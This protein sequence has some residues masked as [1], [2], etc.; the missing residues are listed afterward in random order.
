MKT[1]QERQ[2]DRRRAKLDEV[3]RQVREGSLVVRQMT[4]DERARNQPKPPRPKRS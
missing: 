3:D 2:A 4:D 1:T